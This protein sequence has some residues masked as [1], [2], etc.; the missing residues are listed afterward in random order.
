MR[1]GGY[2]CRGRRRTWGGSR[3]EAPSRRSR[4]RHLGDDGSIRE[5]GDVHP[6][7]TT[8]LNIIEWLWPALAAFAVAAR[9]RATRRPSF[10]G[11]RAYLSMNRSIPL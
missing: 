10:A 7:D 4:P 3:W 11:E 6:D 9:H 2:Q 5:P 8:C 1:P